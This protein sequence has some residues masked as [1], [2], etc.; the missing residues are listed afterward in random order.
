MKA[1]KISKIKVDSGEVV[2]SF[3]VSDSLVLI[4]GGLA[5]AGFKYVL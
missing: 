4:I 3:H 2:P 1:L 5:G